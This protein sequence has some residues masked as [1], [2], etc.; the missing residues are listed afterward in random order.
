MS[1]RQDLEQSND[2]GDEEDTLLQQLAREVVE[3]NIPLLETLKDC[4]SDDDDSECDDEKTCYNRFET[5]TKKEQVM[6]FLRKRLS[7]RIKMSYLQYVDW[8]NDD[9]LTQ[10]DNDVD[11]LKKDDDSL[12][13]EDAVMQVLKDKTVIL[14]RAISEAIDQIGEEDG[15][16]DEGGEAT[17]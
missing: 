4:E 1:K 8:T 12:D 13:T 5:Q 17:D 11:E 15:E 9:T 2:S 3:A 14:D 7:K 16:D 10:I 6:T